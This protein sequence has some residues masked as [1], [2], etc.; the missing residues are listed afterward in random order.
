MVT[1]YHNTAQW[2][3]QHRGS[4]GSAR[5][6][7]YDLYLKT[8]ACLLC[9]FVPPRKGRSHFTKLLT[10]A[11]FFV[12]C[13]CSYIFVSCPG[14]HVHVAGDLNKTISFVADFVRLCFSR[15]HPSEP[16]LPHAIKYFL[17]RIYI[18]LNAF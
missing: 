9:I 2:R 10:R 1:C 14:F 3:L 4:T 11:L 7:D 6:L 5:I 18:E 12:P 8:R 15:A 17:N 16:E 13:H